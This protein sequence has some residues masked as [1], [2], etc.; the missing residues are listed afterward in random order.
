MRLPAD[1]FLATPQFSYTRKICVPRPIIL[2][3]RSE[4]GEIFLR[5]VKK[6]AFILKRSNMLGRVLNRDIKNMRPSFVR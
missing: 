4:Q 3:I 2:N 5:Y 6:E 1:Y